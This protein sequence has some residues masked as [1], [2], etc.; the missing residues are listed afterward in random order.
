MIHAGPEQ[1]PEFDEMATGR[2]VTSVANAP[3]SEPSTWDVGELPKTG[4]TVRIHHG[5]TYDVN[6]PERLRCIGIKPFCWLWFSRTVQTSLDVQHLLVYEGGKLDLGDEADPIVNVTAT[7]N[8]IDAPFEPD[9]PEQWGHG[10]IC[11][12]TLRTHG[13]MR[14]PY[15]RL[16][17]DVSSGDGTIF[18]SRPAYGWQ[19]GDRL[20]LPDSHHLD[21]NERHTDFHR[22]VPQWETVQIA[23]ISANLMNV[24]LTGLCRWNHRGVRDKTGAIRYLPHVQNLTRNVSIRSESATGI[25]GHTVYMGCADVDIRY[26]EF[27]SLGRTTNDP[28]DDAT[29]RKGRYAVHMHHLAGPDKH[30]EHPVGPPTEYQFQCVGNS[31]WCPED[32]HNRRWALVIHDSHYGLVWRN[33]VYNSTGAGIVTEDGNES[34]NTVQ[35]NMVCRVTGTGERGTWG[36][37]GDGFWMRSSNNWLNYNVATDCYG[38]GNSWGFQYNI[39]GVG[40]RGWVKIPMRPGAPESEYVWWFPSEHPLLS[41]DGNEVY[42]AGPGGI[43]AWMLGATTGQ[44]RGD[45]GTIKDFVAWHVYEAGYLAYDSNNLIFEN[46]TILG[47]QSLQV[48]NWLNFG[49]TFGD[50][51][52]R[53]FRI[54]GGE[55]QGAKCGLDGPTNC[56]GP[57][58]IEWVSWHCQVGIAWKTPWSVSGGAGLPAKSLVVTWC[59]YTAPPG[60][61]LWAISMRY[62]WGSGCN[63]IV[64]DRVDVLNHQGVAWDDFRVY[65]YEQAAD[66]IMPQYGQESGDPNRP[67]VGS[68]DYGRTNQQNWDEHSLCI[69]N[70]IAPADV[71]TRA[72]IGGL[73]GLIP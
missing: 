17:S 15:I 3:W 45:A 12:G 16:D 49:F 58:T 13:A 5:V 8:I 73:V 59:I 62:S 2:V 34:W 66:F 56:D 32:G 67:V 64:S 55:I 53:G 69:A 65:Y 6:S 35:G 54:I 27:R 22:Y 72:D 46:P 24:D 51:W 39:D 63:L 44:A 68:P 43:T 23:S 42:G 38:G 4:D 70:E 60:Y 14:T 19:I 21:W 26:T 9:D 33:C 47:D 57:L 37:G 11:L 61:P 7:I 30:C 40:D 18:L 25:R 48:G 29:N 10:V 31:I 20:V 36:R 50:Y 1:I 52:T 28:F 41:C 71:V